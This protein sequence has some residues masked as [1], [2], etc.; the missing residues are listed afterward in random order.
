[1]LFK[2]R[3]CM[4]VVWGMRD[5]SDDSFL[6]SGQSFKVGWVRRGPYEI[7]ILKVGINYDYTNLGMK[8]IS[9]RARLSQ[10]F[11]VGQKTRQEW[12]GM[13]SRTNGTK[14]SGSRW[15]RDLSWTYNDIK[16]SRE[17]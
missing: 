7:F 11:L 1:M 17:T 8:L 9:I 14:W 5:N 3:H 13:T 12:S 4:S 15:A 2:E 10:F 6:K 16:E